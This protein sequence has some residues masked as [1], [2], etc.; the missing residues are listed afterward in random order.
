MLLAAFLG[1]IIL[2]IMPCVF[3]VISLKV[4]SF[5]GQAGEDRKKVFAHSLTFALGIL[6]FFWILTTVLLVL[7]NVGSDDVGWGV[8]L[9]QPGF[10][11][12]LIF[13]MVIVALSLF[14]V[15]EFGASRL[16][17]CRWGSRQRIGIRR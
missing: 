15:F 17:W 4:M 2:N 9:R 14:G 12:G 6:V 7:R 3:P 10:V 8:Q 16:D 5:V 13:V 11:I 1:G